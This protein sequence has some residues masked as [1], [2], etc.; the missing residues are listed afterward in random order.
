MCFSYERNKYYFNVSHRKIFLQTKFWNCMTIHSLLILKK[1][2][3][4]GS[5][6]FH[7][8][9]LKFCTKDHN[10]WNYIVVCFNNNCTYN[11]EFS[12]YF[13]KLDKRGNNR[14]RLHLHTSLWKIITIECIPVSLCQISFCT[15]TTSIEI[16]SHYIVTFFNI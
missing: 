6:F 3:S 13:L 14:W 4:F 2:M 12:K 15:H 7:D 10:S 5:I 9:K 1:C 8:S 16:F 11:V